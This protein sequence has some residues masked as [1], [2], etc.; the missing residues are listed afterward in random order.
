MKKLCEA[1]LA[2]KAEEALA[3]EERI[4]AEEALIDFI[5]TGPCTRKVDGTISR[6]IAGFK[7][8]IEYKLSRELDFE[9]YRALNLESSLE[10]VTLK[11]AIDMKALRFIE[12]R[13]PH[14]ATACI[15]TK[16]AKTA[17]SV[18]RVES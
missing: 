15:T 18:E 12:E 6:R 3:K 2:A 4:K 10:F 7:V 16:P 13:Y 11:P 5:E 9:A 14:L 17:V 8:K 1:L